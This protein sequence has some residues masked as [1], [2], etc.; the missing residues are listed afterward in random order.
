MNAIGRAGID[1]DGVAR[2]SPD[3]RG[4]DAVVDDA[5]RLGDGHQAI[6]GRVEHVD[7]AAGGGLGE[8]EGESLA[9]CGARARAAVGSRSGNPSPVW[10]RLRRRG[11]KTESEKSPGD[12]W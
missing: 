6:A 2:G 10:S 4:A 1:G 5:D 7:L 8:R 9:G 11:G 12:G 3:G